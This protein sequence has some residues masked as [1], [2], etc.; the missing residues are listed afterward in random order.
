MGS[1][2]PNHIDI[3]LEQSQIQ[4]DARDVEDIPQFT[5]RD[6]LLDLIDCRSVFKGVAHHENLS[7]FF[8][9]TDQV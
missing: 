5:A 4:P 7:P 8:C 3:R 9:Q 1:K 6:D 2:I